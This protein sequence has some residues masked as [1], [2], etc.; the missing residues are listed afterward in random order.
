MKVRVENSQN[1]VNEDRTGREDPSDDVVDEQAPLVSK[2]GDDQA[3]Q[4]EA[5]AEHPRVV[6]QSKIFREEKNPAANDGIL[7][8]KRKMRD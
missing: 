4:V 6:G 1:C 2:G 8:K 5:L 7:K 3:M